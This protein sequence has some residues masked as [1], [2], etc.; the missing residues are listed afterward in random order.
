MWLNCFLSL[1]MRKKVKVRLMSVYLCFAFQLSSVERYAVHF[2]ESSYSFVTAEQLDL[3][4][5]C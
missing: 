5:V 1:V 2:V 4:E 3:D